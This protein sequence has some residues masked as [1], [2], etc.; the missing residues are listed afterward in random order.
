MNT[1]KKVCAAASAS[2]ILAFLGGGVSLALAQTSQ[3]PITTK[4][5]LITLFCSVISW[6]I[7]ILLGISV[8]MVLVAGYNYVTAQDDTEKTTKARRTLTYA[9][10]GI[11]VVLIAYG[12][13]QLVSSLFPNNPDVS[14][15]TCSGSSSSSSNNLTT[16]ME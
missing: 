15:F 1:I 9:A 7:A 5:Q 2:A 10:V 14:A 8:V 6:F 16:G 13:P 11:A 4:A 12:F 3:A